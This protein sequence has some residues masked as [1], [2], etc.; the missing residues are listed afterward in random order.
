MRK[1]A[2]VGGGQ[3]G[4]Q[5]AFGLLGQRYEVTVVSNRT[6]E[7]IR[8]G[9]VSSSQF[10]FHDSLQNERD[11]GINFWEKECPPTE[12]IAFSVPGP[13]GGRALYW[14]AKLDR[15]GQ[16]VDQRV[17]FSGWLE[18]FAK[19]GGNVVYEDAGVQELEKYANSHDLLLVAAGK[20]EVARLFATNTAQSPF[21]TP[22]RALALTYVRNM[23]ARKPFT[24]VAF[25][26]IPGVGEYFVF[27]ALT[28]SG[29]CEI[30]VFEGVPGGPMD[31]WGD[32]KTPE[33]HLLRSKE[34]LQKFLP[35]EAERCRDI[36]LTDEMGTLAGRFAPTVRNPVCKLPS[37]RVVL[38][39][40]DVVVL[41]DPITGQGSNTAS[42]AAKV[43]MNRILEHG[44]KP[45]DTAWMQQTFD[46]FWNYAQWVV[47]WTNSLL[48]P[49]PPYILQLMGA[50]SQIPVLASKIANGFNNP[51][52]YNPWWF[53]P[54]EAQKLLGGR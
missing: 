8:K 33:Q 20:G 44:N 45:F 16:S 40:A 24:A 41:N 12:G 28:T 26:L 3:S 25:S 46:S 50:A 49:P 18:E 43:Y 31:C 22:M 52:D 17:K 38:G 27:P 53:D 14:Q 4:L 54:A 37:G 32:V 35:W 39:M 34:I 21:S 29:P 30:M 11:L 9:R 7:Q 23:V 19:R 47:K 10:M 36:E 2:I 48:T 1:I 51:P 15:Y 5:L 13:D 6:P 42:K